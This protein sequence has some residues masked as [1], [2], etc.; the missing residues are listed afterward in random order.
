[1]PKTFMQMAKEAMA[2]VPAIKPEEA[3]KRIK[4]DPSAV[5]VDVRDAADTAETGV[6]PGSLNVSLGML[7]VR[8][9]R[10]LPEAF[11]HP[12]LQDRSR[13]IFTICALGPNSA[14][15]A[16]DLKEMGF[17]NVA[18]IEGGMQSWVQAGL[19]TEKKR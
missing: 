18:F 17:S 13:P 7:A 6:V 19:P 1:M 2:E 15:G 14:R 8:A 10:E 5:V 4:A 16:R 12:D 11:R 9:D 3:Y